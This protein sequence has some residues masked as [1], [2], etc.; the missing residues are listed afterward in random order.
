M[1]LS[2]RRCSSGA[3][4]NHSERWS[5]ITDELIAVG[6]NKGAT[7]AVSVEQKELFEQHFDKQSLSDA[8]EQKHI[9]ARSRGIDRKSGEVFAKNAALELEIASRKCLIGTFKFSP[10]LE[11]LKVK[12]RKSAPRLISIPTIRDR[13]VL[14]QMNS[15]I[16][17]CFPIETKLYLASEYVKIITE[18]FPTLNR[19]TTWTAGL[20]IK[21]FYDSINRDRLR[22]ILERKLSYA[23]AVSLILKA[24]STPTVPKNYRTRDRQRYKE[25]VG[26]PQG[27]AISNSLAALYLSDV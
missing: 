14:T 5:A 9:D 24:I 13:V 2:R 12:D 25:S 6:A 21:R 10:Y 15:Y 18:L 27:L 4:D 20:D 1:V 23:P 8:F 22:K 17:A 19:A 16:R 11:A 7:S 26:I 3:V